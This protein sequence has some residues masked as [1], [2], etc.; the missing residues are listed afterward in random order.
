MFFA[1]NNKP[2]LYMYTCAAKY[3]YLWRDV[4]CTQGGWAASEAVNHQRSVP[5]SNSLLRELLQDPVTM[6][7]DAVTPI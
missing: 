1:E 7:D 2:K 3:R 5:A 4:G 6:A